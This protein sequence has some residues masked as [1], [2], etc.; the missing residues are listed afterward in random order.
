MGKD[1][2]VDVVHPIDRKIHNILAHIAHTTSD[3]AL[4]HRALDLQLTMPPVQDWSAQQH[5]ALAKRQH[6]LLRLLPP[7]V[8]R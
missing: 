6:S 4:R 3:P 7:A 1:Q 2:D 5:R 8:D